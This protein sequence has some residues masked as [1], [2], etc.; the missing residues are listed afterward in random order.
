MFGDLNQSRKMFLVIFLFGLGVFCFLF[1]LLL[2]AKVACCLES[3]G[4]IWHWF[5][6]SVATIAGGQ[7]WCFSSVHG[8]AEGEVIS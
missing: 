6:V 2:S 8:L 7:A 4:A 1:F 3:L 5:G